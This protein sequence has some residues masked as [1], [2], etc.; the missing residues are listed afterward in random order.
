MLYAGYVQLANQANAF[1]TF[2]IND[3]QT[4]SGAKLNGVVFGVAHFF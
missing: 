4:A 1:Y 3:Y 2:N